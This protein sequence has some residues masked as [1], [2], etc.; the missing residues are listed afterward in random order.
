MTYADFCDAFRSEFCS[1]AKVPAEWVTFYPDGWRGSGSR[2]D[3]WLI[4][5]TNRH[6]KKEPAKHLQGDYLVV[7]GPDEEL[8]E[9]T[10]FSLDLMYRIFQQKGWDGVWDF[11]DWSMD[12]AE[13][14]SVSDLFGS[15]SRYEDVK[16]R[17]LVRLMNYQTVK[18]DLKHAIYRR[19][20]DVVLVLYGASKSDLSMC[21]VMKVPGHMP[22]QWGVEEQIIFDNALQ[23]TCYMFPP[24]LYDD[25]YKAFHGSAEDGRFM[26]PGTQDLKICT[27]V[28]T[29]LGT[30]PNTNGAI[31]IFYPGVRERIARILGCSYYLAFLDVHLALLETEKVP[32]CSPK[33]LR[34]LLKDLARQTAPMDMVST[35]VYYYDAEKEELKMLEK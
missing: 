24:R 1:R 15:R 28:V 25:L 17:L 14:H 20:G 7:S 4:R 6:Y 22:R 35:S 16:D 30:Y 19:F 29:F 21:T 3:N 31:A 11:V 33:N 9:V 5:D 10:R 2:F 32:G 13:E 18:A 26:E 8:P 34:G 12:Y 27:E 23:N